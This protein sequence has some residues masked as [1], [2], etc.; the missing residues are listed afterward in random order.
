[1]LDAGARLRLLPPADSGTGG[2][3]VSIIELRRDLVSLPTSGV[4]RGVK[5]NASPA[6]KSS[7]GFEA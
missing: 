4:D 6:V 7:S 5:T 3:V 1:M 2:S